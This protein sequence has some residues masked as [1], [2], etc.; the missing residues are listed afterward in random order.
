MGKGKKAKKDKKRAGEIP[1]EQALKQ[2]ME[3]MVGKDINTPYDE[4]N[5][6]L[7]EIYRK[8]S[9]FEPLAQKI[10]DNKPDWTKVELTD[11][12]LTDDVSDTKNQS[13]PDSSPLICR[14]S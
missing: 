8:Y 1:R 11:V 10:R 2:S 3:E 5:P 12:E 4:A 14:V 13:T 6:H 9:W 7:S